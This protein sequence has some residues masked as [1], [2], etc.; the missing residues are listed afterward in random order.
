VLNDS[1]LFFTCSLIEFIGRERKLRRG[2]VV[3]AL[4]TTVLRRIYSH[5]SVLHCE[6]IESVVNEFVSICQI[7]AGDFSNVEKCRYRVPDF[8]TIGAVYAR[9][10]E[11][12]TPGETVSEL[13]Q[14]LETVYTSWISDAIS[15]FNTDFFYQSREYLREC[16]KAGAVLD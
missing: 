12:V 10:I 1:D 14:T 5:A 16:W 9:L 4:G 8:W 15:N 6:V 13:I 7:P 3:K 11:D 2:E